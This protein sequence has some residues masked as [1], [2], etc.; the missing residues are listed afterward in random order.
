MG[1]GYQ[2][3]CWNCGKVG[4][5]A[6]ECA[7]QRP[8][9]AVDEEADVG[10]VWMVGNVE[11]ETV[12][13]NLMQV[14]VPPG[15]DVA[16]C[17]V[18]R[19]GKKKKSWPIDAETETEQDCREKSYWSFA[20]S[21]SEVLKEGLEEDFE[22]TEAGDSQWRMFRKIEVPIGPVRVA[23]Y[24]PK[25]SRES[26]MRFNVA[27][28]TLQGSKMGH[29]AFLGPGEENKWYHGYEGKWNL[30]ASRMVNDFENSG[31]PVFKRDKSVGARDSEGEGP[32]HYPLQW[33]VFQ[34]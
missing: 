1:K 20:A 2:G 3:I 8:A 15:L 14:E 13:M 26:K 23:E 28:V 29:W 10:S 33:R 22:E 12:N 27:K 21:R 5:K 18:R 9:H 24:K 17:Q 19:K 30:C 4:H 34:H 31:H 25:L 32:G 11:V 7:A 16:W 6:N